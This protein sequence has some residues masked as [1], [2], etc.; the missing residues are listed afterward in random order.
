MSTKRLQLDL[1][2]I[3]KQGSAIDAALE[4]VLATAERTRAAT[5]EIIC[6]KGTGQLKKRVLKWLDQKA[7]KTRYHRLDKD[8]N[9]HGRV[10]VH[11]RWR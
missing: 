5:I 9:N 7:V 4:D 8:M 2:P 3:A 11:F 10:F 6:G 1:H